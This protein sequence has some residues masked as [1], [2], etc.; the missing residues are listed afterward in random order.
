MR[1]TGIGML[2]AVLVLGSCA[3]VAH[4]MPPAHSLTYGPLP[5]KSLVPKPSSQV[6]L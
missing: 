1:L 5:P 4:S 2:L 6:A 3:S